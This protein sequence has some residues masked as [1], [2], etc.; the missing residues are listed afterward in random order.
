MENKDRLD[1]F[2]QH[3]FAE[4]DPE[5]RFAFRE[6]YWQQAQMLIEA[7]ERRKRRRGLFWWWMTG[8]LGVVLIAL[9]WM[10]GGTG[11]SGHPS[12]AGT[13][14]TP[15]ASAPV[16]KEGLEEAR[17]PQTPGHSGEP[18]PELTVSQPSGREQKQVHP[19]QVENLPKHGR[20]EHPKRGGVGSSILDMA[21]S[22]SP[23]IGKVSNN[24]L[25]RQ[26]PK[27]L[28]PSMESQRGIAQ[29]QTNNN[30]DSETPEIKGD[31]SPKPMRLVPPDFLP[32]H[33]RLLKRQPVLPHMPP[34]SKPPVAEVKPQDKWRWQLGGLAS[35]SSTTGYLNQKDFGL[36]L[37]LSARLTL[38]DSP[39]SLNADL[40]W[41]SR[42]ASVVDTIFI[43]NTTQSRYSFGYVR[44]IQERRTTSTT[45]LE[46]PVYLQY[47]RKQFGVEL[48][49]MPV[50]LLALRGREDHYRQ[51]S[52]E[53]EKV[54]VTSKKIKLTNRYFETSDLSL[55]A[56]LE[57]RP[58]SRLGF[59]LRLHYQPNRPW[60]GDEY[61]DAPTSPVW[62]DLRTRFF[63]VQKKNKVHSR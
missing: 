17:I 15:E 55:F 30:S 12:G 28:V 37:G 2:L 26:D 49:V 4:D 60:R 22:S 16:G 7:D 61:F 1:E 56:G 40:Q 63:I 21:P 39:F 45:W 62:L 23:A 35:V 41:R 51:T 50:R 27:G 19:P 46:I 14:F 6:E 29:T 33:L 42:K 53:P 9:W 20:P 52:L 31:V 32:T 48:G 5:Q 36:G 54:F 57:C 25:S 24:Q 13:S 44:N 59:G 3:K 47:S 58:T 18:A 38:W 10:S 11:H 8:G 34:A 43:K